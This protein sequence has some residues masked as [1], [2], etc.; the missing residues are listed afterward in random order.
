MTHINLVFDNGSAPQVIIADR[1]HISELI[2]SSVSSF[3]FSVRCNPSVSSV[4][5]AMARSTS[6]GLGFCGFCSRDRWSRV[7]TEPGWSSGTSFPTFSFWWITTGAGEGLST[8]T[9]VFWSPVRV[10][11]CAIRTPSFSMNFGA[12]SKIAIP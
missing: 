7:H 5:C 4:I 6:G 3:L 9:K 8:R 1:Q 10:K 11:E 12:G 2:C